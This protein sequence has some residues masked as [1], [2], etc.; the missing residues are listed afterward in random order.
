MVESTSTTPS[1]TGN[2]WAGGT[3]DFS[4]QLDAGTL[5][6]VSDP[7]TEQGGIESMA[8]GSTAEADVITWMLSKNTHSS[9]ATNPEGYLDTFALITAIYNGSYYPGFHSGEELAK[10]YGIKL[11]FGE[12][13]MNV[14]RKALEAMFYDGVL[15]IPDNYVRGQSHLGV[16][17]GA[18]NIGRVFRGASYGDT[19]SHNDLTLSNGELVTLFKTLGQ[20]VTPEQAQF[21][22]NLYGN[23]AFLTQA[24]LQ[25]MRDDGF[26]TTFT[27]LGNGATLNWDA[28]SGEMIS[29][30]LCSVVGVDPGIGLLAE[31]FEAAT[32][33]VFGSTAGVNTQ[34]AVFLTRLFGT[35]G[36]LSRGQIAALFENNDISMNAASADGTVRT[37]VNTTIDSQIDGALLARAMFAE[38][39]GDVNAE[40]ATINA[41]QFSTGFKNLYA[42]LTGGKTLEGATEMTNY[43]GGGGTITIAQMGTCLNAINHQTN[44]DGVLLGETRATQTYLDGSW[45]DTVMKFLTHEAKTV[46][47]DITAITGVSE[48]ILASI[49]NGDLTKDVAFAKGGYKFVSSLSAAIKAGEA[50]AKNVMS[51]LGKAISSAVSSLGESAK[52]MIDDMV[53]EAQELGDE[54]TIRTLSMMSGMSAEEA[55]K[56]VG[57]LLDKGKFVDKA[58]NMSFEEMSAW[59]PDFENV[60]ANARLQCENGL[61]MNDTSDAAKQ[62]NMRYDFGVELDVGLTSGFLLTAGSVRLMYSFQKDYQGHESQQ[63]RLRFL[64]EVG[65]GGAIVPDY[66]TLDGGMATVHDLILGWTLTDG[67][68]YA[69]EDT[70][71][72]STLAVVG[73]GQAPGF[74]FGVLGHAVPTIFDI[75]WKASGKKGE[76]EAGAGVGMSVTYNLMKLGKKW[77]APFLAEA[78][79]AA[80]P[81]GIATG[82]ACFFGPAARAE[83]AMVELAAVLPGADTP[84]LQAVAVVYAAV[85]VT[86]FAADAIYMAAEKDSDKVAFTAGAFGF[87]AAR[88]NGSAE[89]KISESP[90]GVGIAVGARGQANWS[91]APLVTA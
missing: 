57:G 27:T 49:L 59:I 61:A 84:A 41:D 76:F 91:S 47:S 72:N 29:A 30:A 43:F 65:I 37:N 85:M 87:V 48:D 39:G 78:A 3:T 28:I 55:K 17:L 1:E 82:I 74:L 62:Q 18:L 36:K 20:T 69:R 16:N 88:V 40:G 51:S 50:S 42:G 21:L 86:S 22:V 24:N 35:G 56:M 79:G 71:W 81:I 54:A 14:G 10:A 19:N 23:G 8:S 32:A 11:T 64:G 70:K 68:K 52:I 2:T 9:D 80:V 67:G 6:A 83:G 44:T 26:L 46:V 73:E 4:S 63:F 5:A 15:F 38:G 66:F 60:Q 90:F 58:N 25:S 53:K 31:Q 89:V 13:G 75:G 33:K 7:T 12:V 77:Y 34:Q 45:W